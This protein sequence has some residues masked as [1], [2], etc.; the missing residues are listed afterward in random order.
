MSLTSAKASLNLM[1]LAPL[2]PVLLSFSLPVDSL[3]E[4]KNEDQMI[5]SFIGDQAYLT[6]SPSSSSSSSNKSA[7][8]KSQDSPRI[9]SKGLVP[10]F[11][12]SFKNR[13]AVKKILTCMA[14]ISSQTCIKFIPVSL[15][16]KR[17]G[18]KIP[19]HIQIFQGKD[20]ECWSVFGTHD[21]HPISL[22]NGCWDRG[23]ILH[24]LMHA[25][26]FDHSHTRPDRDRYIRI[27]WDSID[28][29]DWDEFMIRGNSIESRFLKSTPFDYSSIMMYGEWNGSI[30]DVNPAIT[31]R[32]GKRLIDLEDKK[33]L[34][35]SDIRL[36]NKVYQCQR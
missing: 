16:I 15:L 13:N 20:G 36:V 19:P 7:A 4:N 12:H 14:E 5:L 3:V 18:G 26:G 17:N 6:D 28:T 31:R 2:L 30:D 27:H 21:V 10:Y 1:K 29:R 24:E 34:S 9:W 23:T 32:D 25:L 11:F 22:S 8:I 35:A 33:R